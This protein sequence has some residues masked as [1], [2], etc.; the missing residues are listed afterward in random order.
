[1]EPQELRLWLL[2][3]QKRLVTDKPFVQRYQDRH[4]VRRHGNQTY[5]DRQYSRFQVLAD[6]L[7][8]LI[9]SV[10]ANVDQYAQEQ[11]YIQELEAELACLREAERRRLMDAALCGT[12][13]AGRE[14]MKGRRW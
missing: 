1:M 12:G 2:E 3:R 8:E 14:N 5:A 13:T 11:R 6:D 4:Q 10:I 9:D 7:L